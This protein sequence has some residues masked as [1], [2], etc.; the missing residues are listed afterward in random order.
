ML[1]SVS[2][3]SRFWWYRPEIMTLHNSGSSGSSPA[4]CAD[5]AA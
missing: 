1:F 3:R 5:V 2:E 4:G